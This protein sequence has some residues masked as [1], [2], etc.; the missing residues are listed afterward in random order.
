MIRSSVR[1]WMRLAKDTP[2]GYL[3]AA[4]T[5]GGL[6]IPSLSTSI[7]LQQKS[8]FEKLLSS[9]NPLYRALTDQASFCKIM[10]RINVPSRIGGMAVSSKVEAKNQW[11]NSLYQSVDGR[12][13]AQQDIDRASYRW[14]EKTKR[15]F[16]RLHLRGFQLRGGVLLT[17]SRKA[18]GRQDPTTDKRCRGGCHTGNIKSYIAEM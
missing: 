10:R 12:E 17:K 14:I 1:G 16:P 7:P 5:N 6:N 11:A 18:R 13:L 4:V 15:V 8:C 2:L 3:H 9:G